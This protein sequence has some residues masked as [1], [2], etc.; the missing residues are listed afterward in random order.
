MTSPKD[1]SLRIGAS[2]LVSKHFTLLAHEFEA[3]AQGKREMLNDTSKYFASEDT[4]VIIS[5]VVQ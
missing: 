5:V 3:E 4:Y 1:R 2:K